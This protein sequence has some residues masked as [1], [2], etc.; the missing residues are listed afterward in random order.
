MMTASRGQLEIKV[1]QGSMLTFA[2]PVETVLVANPNVLDVEMVSAR[3]AYIYGVSTGTTNLFALTS[4][5]QVLTAATVRVSQDEAAARREAARVA[6]TGGGQIGYI[7][8]R[9]VTT[10]T[11]SNLGGAMKLD[12][13][14]QQ[15]QVSP[16]RTGGGGGGGAGEAMNLSTITGS[17]QVGIRVRFAE[18]SRTAIQN[19]GINWRALFNIGNFNF[20]IVSGAFPPGVVPGFVTQPGTGS[21]G[22]HSSEASVDAVLD[23]LQQEGLVSILAEPTLTAVSGKTANFLAGG[24][25]PIP[26]PQGNET[27]S[28]EYKQFGVSLAFTPTVLPGD[29]IGIRVQ[30][31]VSQLS[32]AGALQ[33]SG[34]SIPALTVRRADTTIELAS[35]QTFAMAGLFQRNVSNSAD[36]IP[37]LGD[38][39]I[40][41]KL[42]QS[43]QYQRNETELVILI[44]PY[45]MN[46]TTA[47]NAM[48]LPAQST[49][50]TVQRA[51]NSLTGGNAG[52][53]LR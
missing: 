6:A 39:P 1:G 10:G 35:G 25:F 47:P 24:E 3:S 33:E 43:S 26:V 27:I 37:L 7:Q 44:T 21:F 5:D 42:F 49:A 13:L 30:P 4:A 45:L 16:G 18:V 8:D 9:P 46:P 19:L 11:A 51:R 14:A 38:L 41:G 12:A 40:L 20:G 32:E 34:F 23:A 29:R 48:A 31:E 50:P 52:F 22:Y 17:Q 15:L 2:Q 36:Q 53:M 28:I